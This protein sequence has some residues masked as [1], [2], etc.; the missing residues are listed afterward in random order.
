M[1]LHSL[2]S[3]I[4]SISD[5]SIY[6]RREYLNFPLFLKRYHIPPFF[7]KRKCTLHPVAFMLA[8]IEERMDFKIIGHVS[9]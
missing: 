9:L 1:Q 8:I 4:S 6:T 3:S 7:I 2:V 5:A